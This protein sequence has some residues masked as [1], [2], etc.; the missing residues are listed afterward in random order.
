MRLLSLVVL[1]IAVSLLV[2]WL[3]AQEAPTSQLPH[4]S[5]Y[6]LDPPQLQ[7]AEALYRI[8]VAR[9]I[10]Y[11]LYT[12]FL[13]FLVL[14]SR[15]ATRF[16]TIAESLSRFRAVQAFGV[17]A[18]LLLTISVL[19]LPLDAHG[20]RVAVQY[21]L[22]VQS[23]GAWLWDVAKGFTV[24]LVIGWLL[25]WGFYALIRK[26]QRKWWL[27]AWL[28]AMPVAMMG[29]FI[30]PIIID[31]I[32]NHYEPLAATH[33]AL[34]RSIEEVV[35]RA[36]LT[37]PESRIFEMRASEKVT[38]YN[39]YVTGIGASKR[40]V[41]WDTTARDLP[42]DSTLYVFGHEMGHYVLHHIWKGGAF[43]S[44]G[45]FFAF[46]I[47]FHVYRYLLPRISERTGIRDA[48]DFASLPLVLL[49]AFV[50]S[51]F[52]EPIQSAFSRH[53]EHQADIYGLEAIHTVVPDPN[54]AAAMS[55]QKI[56]E[57][58]LAI[59]DPSPLLV[60]WSYDHPTIASRVRFCLEYRPW[61]EGKPGKYFK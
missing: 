58:G 57:A 18:L 11:L 19:T 10:G 50:L 9:Y 2:P 24:N 31:P 43:A 37:I 53:L 54:T 12:P 61:E 52:S 30:M 32:F 56:G 42:F 21:G 51:F 15:G 38:T 59:P 46:L 13:L 39:A 44:V 36:G 25:V 47:L 60:F 16:R 1:L 27:A 23:W 28:C 48:G 6:H 40:I 35:G 33:P 22:S 5:A 14:W 45:L 20:H 49:I 8:R 17:T 34:T 3:A 4:I 26:F 29:V 41:V 55:F 7:K